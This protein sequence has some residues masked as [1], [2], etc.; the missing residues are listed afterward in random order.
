MESSK[1]TDFHVKL[2]GQGP[3]LMMIHGIISDGTFFDKSAAC[4]SGNY[5]VLTYDRRGY[6][7]NNAKSYT[8]YSVEAQ[9][10]DAADILKE[11]QETPAWV[12]GNSAGG[13]IALE[14]ALR[15]PELVRGLILLEPSLGYDPS[16]REKLLA[17]NRELNGYLKEGK[18]KRALPAFSR[19]I[20]A[21]GTGNVSGSLQE[22][23]RTY[24][25]LQAF[26]Y[27]ELNE[28]QHYLPPVGKLQAL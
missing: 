7:E 6:G 9:A 1:W 19:V 2:S 22:L 4:L 11:C 28:V 18:I 17:W 10:E 8:D 5:R 27:G 26:M 21:D 24:Q 3:L 13:L 16:E 14:L 20:G 12:L 23:R 15:Y 25:N